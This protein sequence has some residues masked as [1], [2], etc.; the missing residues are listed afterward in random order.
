MR[1]TLQRRI[2]LAVLAFLWLP[3]AALAAS[4]SWVASMPG[5]LVA[6]SDRPSETR[7][8]TPPP[9]TP[10]GEGVISQVQWRWEPP[11][12]QSVNAWLCHPQSCLALPMQLGSTRAFAGVS[13]QTPLHFRFTLPQ[14]H[15]PVRVQGMQIIVN[16]Q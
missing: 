4:G 15:R 1:N 13:A 7:R 6:M 14:G 2:G 11:P 8:A 3:A 9:G 5:I 16:Y 12:G 10:V